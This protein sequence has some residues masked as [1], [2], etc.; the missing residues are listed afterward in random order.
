MH[1]QPSV[2]P[3][4][5]PCGYE[6]FAGHARSA[7]VAPRHPGKHSQLWPAQ[8]PW[9]HVALQPLEQSTPLQPR[10]HTQ[11][12]GAAHLPCPLHSSAAPAALASAVISIARRFAAGPATAATAAFVGGECGS[13]EALPRVAAAV[14]P[15]SAHAQ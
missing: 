3:L 6:Q 15:S 4:H 5:S 2:A 14:G 7:H 9:T 11:C 13:G 8:T 1:W 10:S 12:P